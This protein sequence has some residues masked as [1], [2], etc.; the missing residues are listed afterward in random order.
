MSA[1]ISPKLAEIDQ[2]QAN[3]IRLT[4]FPSPTAEPGKSSWWEEIV[5]EVPDTR[6]DQPRAQ[7]HRVEGPLGPGTLTLVIQPLR[8]DWH[9]GPQKEDDSLPPSAP[10]IGNLPEIRQLFI[11]TITPWLELKGLPPIQRLAY[12]VV[13]LLPVDDGP[14][15][16]EQMSAYLPAIEIDSAGSS[17]FMYQINRPRESKSGIDDM[18]INRLS[19][20]S[21]LKSIG[22]VVRLGS[23]VLT[24][25]E[26]SDYHAIRIELDINTWADFEGD[27]PTDGLVPLIEEFASLGNEIVERGDIP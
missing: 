15:G 12:G 19:K 6:V 10:T 20:W 24:R 27:L 16:Y 18:L 23:Q 14:A 22:S 4:A 13:V 7:A 11:D 8:I 17:D 9:L 2:W 21:V 3:S 1:K 25:F 26:A 5:G